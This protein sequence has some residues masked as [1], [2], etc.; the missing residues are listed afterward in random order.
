[1]SFTPWKCSLFARLIFALTCETDLACERLVASCA[2]Y[3]CRHCVSFF[4]PKSHTQWR[5]LC[6][7]KIGSHALTGGRMS[8]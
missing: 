7:V 4:V 3:F 8:P 2:D 1:M 5:S 6:F